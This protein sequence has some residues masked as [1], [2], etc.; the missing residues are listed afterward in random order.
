[1]RRLKLNDVPTIMKDIFGNSNFTMYYE[2]KKNL[3]VI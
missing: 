3:T 2:D 1:M